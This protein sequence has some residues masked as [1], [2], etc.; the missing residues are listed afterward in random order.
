MKAFN[1]FA[2]EAAQMETR[3]RSK[4]LPPLG[5][6]LVR[7]AKKSRTASGARLGLSF[8]SLGM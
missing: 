3:A 7:T 6:E 4:R 2:A 1:E 8:V 5:A